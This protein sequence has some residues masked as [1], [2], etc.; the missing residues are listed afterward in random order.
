MVDSDT[1]TGLHLH[2]HTTY[3]NIRMNRSYYSSHTHTKLQHTCAQVGAHTNRHINTGQEEHQKDCVSSSES[4]LRLM[5]REN[6]RFWSSQRVLPP[7][8]ETSINCVA[9]HYSPVRSTQ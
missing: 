9:L 4:V 5:M 3:T 2:K 8:G 1:N 6:L 7:P